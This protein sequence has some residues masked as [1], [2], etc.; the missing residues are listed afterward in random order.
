MSILNIKSG[1][2]TESLLATWS[3]GTRS[4]IRSR[5]YFGYN[6]NNV[7]DCTAIFLLHY[8][9]VS[10]ECAIETEA[11]HGSQPS[12]D[13]IVNNIQVLDYGRKLSV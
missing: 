11:I 1:Q 9:I 13:V 2:S 12:S 6:I 8:F 10:G 3:T 7:N 4:S 5:P